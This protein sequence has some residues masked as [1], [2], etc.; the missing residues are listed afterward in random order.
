MIN[1]SRNIHEE[2]AR[3]AKVAR[4][5][6][7]AIARRVTA[8]QVANDPAIRS[9]LLTAADVPAPRK[10]SPTWYHV[11]AALQRHEQ[12]PIIDGDPFEGFPGGER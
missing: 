2:M 6:E 3:S 4:L 10:D 1:R 7:H 11:V 12:P 9:M 5:F 8:D